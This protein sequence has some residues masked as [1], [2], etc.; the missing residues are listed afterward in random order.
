MHFEVVQDTAEKV[1]AGVATI[2][3]VV[4]IGVDLHVE[5]LVGLH[6]SLRHLSA[7]AEMHIVI[8]CAVN[9]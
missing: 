4:A 3:A 1:M 2:D 9:E 7:V 5:R 6:Q 8:G